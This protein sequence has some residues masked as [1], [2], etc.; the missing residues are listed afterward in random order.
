MDWELGTAPGRSIRLRAAVVAGIFAVGCF[1]VLLGRLYYIQFVRDDLYAPRAAGQQLR[2]IT[3]TAPRGTIYDAN[4]EPLAVSATAWTIRAV[5]REMADEDVQPAAAAL[6]EILELDAADVLEKLNQRSSND[7]LL[8][9]RVDK[10]MA[11]AVRLYCAEN[12]VEGI[13]V[14]EDSR[15]YYPQ[16]DLAGS[17]LGFVNVDGDGVA[18]LEL[19]YNSRLKGEDGSLLAAKNAWGY[20]LPDLYETLS[21]PTQGSSLVLTIDKN[22][23]SY[24]ENYLSRAVAEY[25]VQARG[26]GIV[27]DVD[28]G[29]IL[30]MSTKP[31]YDPNQPRLLA[32]QTLQA[33]IDALPDDQRA[34]ALSLAQQAQWRNK[35]VSDLYEPGSVFKIITASAALDSGA[36]TR[37]TIFPCRGAIQV[38]GTTFHCANGKIHGSLNIADAL[39]NSCNCSFIQIGAALGRERFYQYFEAFGLTG[40]TGIDLPAEPK[41]S[42]FYTAERMGPVELASCSF[43]QS[44]KITPIQMITAVSAAVN[45]GHLMQP[46]LVSQI[47][48]EEGAVISQTQPVEKRQVISQ[49]ASDSIREML[50]HTVDN[51]PGKNAYV[52]GFRVGGKSGTSQK[53]DSDNSAARIASF[54][55]VA[56]ADDPKIAVLVVL[57]EPN[58]FSSS[59]GT[60]AAPVVGQVIR[61]TLQYLDVAPVYTAEEREKVETTVPDVTGIDRHDASDRLAAAGLNCSTRGQQSTVTGQSPAAGQVLPRGSTV[62]LY[63]EDTQPAL[64]TVPSLEGL[65]PD[66]AAA[67]LAEAGLNLA[68]LGPAN[69]EGTVA[70]GQ[71]VSA[72]TMLPAGSAV[73]VSFYDP[74]VPAD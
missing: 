27:M 1:G 65:T 56:P 62:V 50:R 51:G 64:V 61:D 47:L 58:T 55:G 72:G 57:D 67:R 40:A 3:V 31:D 24:L 30:A 60:L 22:I 39:L 14:L 49:A 71:S 12:G 20:P 4:L 43:G 63:T 10:E 28:T 44:S 34:E 35:A 68:A 73:E 54:V 59:G 6:A 8:R 74:S 19:E 37:Q 5:P 23:Q 70:A 18:G 2:G 52:A 46:Y 13:L 45:G 15:R 26:V 7:A 17:I 66:Q 36:V 11:D 29:A 48:D 16:G 33:Q 69:Q 9:R 25:N 32:D 53:L 42:E 21:A 41:K 38:S